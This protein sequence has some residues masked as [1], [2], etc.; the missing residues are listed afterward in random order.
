[1]STN[2][3]DAA[4]N[5]AISEA[6]QALAGRLPGHHVVVLVRA[7]SGHIG[8]Y[9]E[10]P[11]INDHPDLV[12]ELQRAVYYIIARESVEDARK[13]LDPQ[14]TAPG[15]SAANT[16]DRDPPTPGQQLQRRLPADDDS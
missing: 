16:A 14:P 7:P 1:M 8:A 4:V 15:G 3:S 9:A 6:A 11:D 10:S 5:V 2:R 13:L 12:G